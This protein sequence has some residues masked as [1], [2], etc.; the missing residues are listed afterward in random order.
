MCSCSC[1]R[2][3]PRTPKGLE[4]HAQQLD[5]HTLSTHEPKLTLCC[6][7]AILRARH[8]MSELLATLALGHFGQWPVV[9]AAA[10]PMRLGSVFE[11]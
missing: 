4:Q 8:N 6:P 3:L 7:Q 11:P 1:S 9:V 5:S 2:P 10:L